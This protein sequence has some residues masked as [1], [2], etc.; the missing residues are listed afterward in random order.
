MCRGVQFCPQ[1][2][3]FYVVERFAPL[4]Y[5]F[6]S[7][8]KITTR[9]PYSSLWWH[10]SLLSHIMQ[11]T[12]INIKKNSPDTRSYAAGLTLVCSAV[13]HLKQC[14]FMLDEA[15]SSI[16]V[17]QK[18]FRVSQNSVDY[19]NTCSAFGLRMSFTF[20]SDAVHLRMRKNRPT[21]QIMQLACPSDAVRF[22]FKSS[23]VGRMMLVIS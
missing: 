20:E 2:V 14:D 6:F 22:S 5:A 7:F 21:K 1:E 23:E 4:Y 8:K 10:C 17:S 15:H 3:Q 9:I 16:W 12:N 19:I 13:F 18:C 11:H